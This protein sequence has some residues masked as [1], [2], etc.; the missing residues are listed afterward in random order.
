MR[1]APADTARIRG[2]LAA[3]QKAVEDANRASDTFAM[4]RELNTLRAAALRADAIIQDVEATTR[5]RARKEVE[6]S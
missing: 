4:R 2:A 3:V 6:H 5:E 1:L